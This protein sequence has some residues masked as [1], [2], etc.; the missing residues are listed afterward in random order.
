MTTEEDKP[1]HPPGYF[2]MLAIAVLLC[3]GGIVTKAVLEEQAGHLGLQSQSAMKIMS[4]VWVADYGIW[5][6]VALF[7]I[8]V[9]TKGWMSRR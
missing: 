1:K 8:L 4:I 5:I 9:A 2:A 6:G 7:V 3:G